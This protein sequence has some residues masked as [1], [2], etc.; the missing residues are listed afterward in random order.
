MKN[1]NWDKWEITRA[2][3]MWN[4][5]LIYGVLA[6]GLMTGLLFGISFPLYMM[7][8]GSELNLP[9]SAFLLTVSLILFPIGGIVWGYCM[10]IFVEKAYWENKASELALELNQSRNG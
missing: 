9:R 7:L 10:W 8:C 3:G 2:K 6:W 5:I 4:Y 1:K